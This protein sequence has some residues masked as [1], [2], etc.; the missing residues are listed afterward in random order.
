[1][2]SEA[3]SITG[4]TGF[5][6]AA[7]GASARTA[8]VAAREDDAVDVAAVIRTLTENSANARALV[9]RLPG[10]LQ[11]RPAPCPCGCDRALEHAVMTAP[12][13]RDPALVAR[14]DAVAGRVL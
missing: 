13:K 2:P 14:L 12:D 7:G 6:G 3:S 9:A 10:L 5:T 1:M 8:E 4:T 11:D